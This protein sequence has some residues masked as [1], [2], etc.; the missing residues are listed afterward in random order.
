MEA[1]PTLNSLA[2]AATLRVA[3]RFALGP[4]IQAE[5]DPHRLVGHAIR[6]DRL[7]VSPPTEALEEGDVGNLH[8]RDHFGAAQP[9]SGADCGS[10]Q[11]LA[12][13][14]VSQG[15]CHGQA[16]ALP[17]TGSV[18]PVDP[19]RAP[20]YTPDVGYEVNRRIVTVMGILVGRIEHRLRDDE[21]LVP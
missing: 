13:H 20:C 7:A 15:R 14:P 12:D 17:E 4:W 9:A 11:T 6:R 18:Q 8:C 1:D 5:A 3:W 21:D 16:I 10:D 2:P 19:D